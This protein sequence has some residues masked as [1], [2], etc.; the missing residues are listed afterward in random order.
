MVI[1]RIL[2]LGVSFLGIERYALEIWVFYLVW[3]ATFAH[4]WWRPRGAWAEQCRAIATL[5]VFAIVL[6][7][8]TTG[9]HLLRSLSMPHLWPVAGVDIGLL[10]LASSCFWHQPLA[11]ARRTAGRGRRPPIY[12]RAGSHA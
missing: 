9:D 3:I 7:W 4:A 8:V 11:V 12:S 10:A 5:A 1:N 2:P 6:N